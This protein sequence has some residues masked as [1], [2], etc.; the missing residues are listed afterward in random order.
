MRSVDR[1]QDLGEVFT[2][3]YLVQEMLDTIVDPIS[4]SALNVLEPACGN[5]NFLVEILKRRLENVENFRL[6]PEGDLTH[7]VVQTSSSLYGIDIDE[8]NVVECRDRLLDVVEQFLATKDGANGPTVLALAA[9]IF[10]TNI[11]VGDSLNRP[12]DI[13]LVSYVPEAQDR[14]VLDR[15][16]FFLEEPERDLFF[17]EPPT[18]DPIRLSEFLR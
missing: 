4:D 9:L 13:L 10:S 18:L 11:V 16:Y 2:P 17:V 5:G 6:A 15:S 12:Q 3:P 7:L 14:D 1:A 8:S